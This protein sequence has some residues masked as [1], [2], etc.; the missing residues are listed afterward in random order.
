MVFAGA[1]NDVIAYATFSR[2]HW[3]KLRTISPLERLNKEIKRRTNVVGMFPNDAAVLRVVGAIFAERHD[4]WQTS[5]NRYLTKNNVTA[6]EL[7]QPVTLELEAAIH[8]QCRQEHHRST[9]CGGRLSGAD[10]RSSRSRLQ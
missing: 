7:D 10:P 8:E 6:L 9:A 5:N 4:E 2:F 3:R 1:E